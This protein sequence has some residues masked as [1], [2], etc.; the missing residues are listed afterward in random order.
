MAN[1][2]HNERYAANDA[3]DQDEILPLVNP[4]VAGQ[5][6][7]DRHAAA[8]AVRLNAWGEARRLPNPRFQ[9]GITA[10]FN[11]PQ[12]IAVVAVTSYY[13]GERSCYWPLYVWSIVYAINKLIQFVVSGA[14]LLEGPNQPAGVCTRI[15][16]V[17]SE[18]LNLV[19]FAWFIV[20]NF[21]VFD[22]TSDCPTSSPHIYKLSLGLLG[23][24]YA[25][26]MLPCI[27]AILLLPMVF[28]CFPQVVAF[29]EMVN[30]G[31][32]AN[33]GATQDILNR[34]DLRNYTSGSLGADV[35]SSCV[36]CTESYTENEPIRVLP[37]HKSHHFHQR[38][39]DEWL[40]A[41]SSCPFCKKSVIE[42]VAAGAEAVV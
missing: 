15:F 2:H 38:C 32:R 22:S 1:Y 3:H 10:F 26:I 17:I 39:V 40:L 36:I 18:P 12:I 13:W 19:S 30:R 14:V 11:V 31:A 5:P 37:C 9:F 33:R 28:C 41:N 8:R 23:I 35:D 29:M 34:L 4:R 16:L 42:G 7:E 27:L 20:G 21:W 24:N 6:I 25:V